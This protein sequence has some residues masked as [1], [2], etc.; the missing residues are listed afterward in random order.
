MGKIR[1]LVQEHNM[2]RKDGTF[3]SRYRDFW[4]QARSN[5]Y[6]V[7]FSN[8]NKIRKMELIRPVEEK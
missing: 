6:D 3:K 8:D 5:N 1:D 7:V 4:N 2:F